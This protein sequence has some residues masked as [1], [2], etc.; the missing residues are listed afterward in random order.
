[1][2]IIPSAVLIFVVLG[3]MMMGL[4]TPTEAGAM[5]AVGAIVLAAIHHK[6]FSTTGRKILI[7]GVIAA[8][9][10]TIVGIFLTRGP[11]LQDSPSP[12]PISRWSGSASRPCAF[13]TCAT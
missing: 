12:S 8:G 11:G 1:M 13:P 2:G 7:V 3:T 4:A 6:D 9:I 10:G 5:G